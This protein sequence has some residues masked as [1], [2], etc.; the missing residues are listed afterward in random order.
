MTLV[1]FPTY[2]GLLAKTDY[3]PDDD[4]ENATRREAELRDF[5][6]RRVS[7]GGVETDF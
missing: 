2:Y 3:G 6:E 4:F 7:E 1:Y 5:V